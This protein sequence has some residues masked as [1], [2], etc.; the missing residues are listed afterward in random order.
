MF[1]KET[2]DDAREMDT[3][4]QSQCR[5]RYKEQEFEATTRSGIPLKMVYGPADIAHIDFKEIG[6]PGSYPF[7]RGI[8]PLQYQHQP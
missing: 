6:M 3:R 5:E 2:L 7:T 8:Y 1:S 4:W